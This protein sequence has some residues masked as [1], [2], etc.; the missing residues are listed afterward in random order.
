M[1]A[2]WCFVCFV[3]TA[4]Y[5]FRCVE[6]LRVWRIWWHFQWHFH[7]WNP[8][9]SQWRRVS[10]ARWWGNSTRD[11]AQPGGWRILLIE[12]ELLPGMTPQGVA[13][14]LWAAAASRSQ[15]L[16]GA[17]LKT[18][19]TLLWICLKLGNTS[20]WQ[21]YWENWW[22]II[23]YNHENLVVPMGPYFQTIPF[24]PFL[25]TSKFF[26]N[27]GTG[28]GWRFRGRS[29]W[30][31]WVHKLLG[32]P[33]AVD[34]VVF[35]HVSRLSWLVEVRAATKLKPQEL[36]NASWIDSTETQHWF[37]W[38]LHWLHDRY[39]NFARWARWKWKFTMG[40]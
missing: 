37:W 8:T 3:A 24:C 27:A 20:K 7:W 25:N 15:V 1:R 18:C 30:N 26:P 29:W 40:W 21:F 32:S 13:N 34:P 17:G 16:R 14:R 19:L 33:G 6:V 35:L 39:E 10:R 4:V 9:G 11:E 5:F 31:P 12:S 38:I 36:S 22:M 2:P 28:R 23:S